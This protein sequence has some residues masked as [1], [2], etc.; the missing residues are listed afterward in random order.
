[1][2]GGTVVSKLLCVIDG[3]ID[4]DFTAAEYATLS[5]LHP[6]EIEDSIWGEALK[7][8]IKRAKPLQKPK[9]T[10]MICGAEEAKELARLLRMDLL[11]VPGATG[12]TN[13][14]LGAKFDAALLALKHYGLVVLHINGADRAAHRKAPEEKKLFL[15]KVDKEVYARLLPSAHEV[16]VIAERGTDPATGRRLVGGQR[17]FSGHRSAQAVQTENGREW[18]IQTL[19]RKAAVLG[20]LPRKA[21][22]DEKTRCRIKYILGPWPRALEAAGLKERNPKSDRGGRK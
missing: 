7:N 17:A 15:H 18:A 1:M 19:R 12:D 4:Q 2:F 11:Q 13:T 3:M 5:A 6:I 10:A 20:A 9:R 14:D 21:D 8:D 22:F 16:I